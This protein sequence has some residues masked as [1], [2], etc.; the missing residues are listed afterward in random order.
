MYPF[1]YTPYDWLFLPG[2]LLGIYAQI[3]LSSAYN[4]YSQIAISSG[5][6]G[7]EAAREILD[8]AGLTDIPVEEIPGH[9]TDHFDPSRRALFLSS[10]NFHE[11]SIAAVGVAAHETG[12]ALQQQAS[13]ALFNFRMLLVP[14]TQFASY[15]WM[16]V[17][18][19][20]LFLRGALGVKLLGVA[21]GV[22]AVLTLFQIVTLPVEFDASRRAKQQLLRLG[23]VQ[24][25][26]SVGV[27]RVLD[28]AAM[29]YV[30]AMVNSILQL[31]RLIALFDD[32]NRRN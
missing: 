32:R 11:R 6:S 29:T 5:L 17:F 18:L 28:A 14:A 27:N 31:L 30:A 10:E 20:G 19:L 24:S 7:A 25:D 3:K 23:L 16:G 9:L 26:E 1:Y 21:I 12:H 22:F 2:L 13:Y 15:A 4:R 8:R